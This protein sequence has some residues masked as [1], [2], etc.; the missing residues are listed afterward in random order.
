MLYLSLF[1]KGH[2]QEYFDRLMAVW[3]DGKWEDWLKFFLRGVLEVS[4][5]A[6]E[7]ARSILRLRAAHGQLIRTRIKG[8]AVGLHLLDYLYEQPMVTVRMG[9][10]ARLHFQ[11]RQ[12]AHA[13]IRETGSSHRGGSCAA[14]PPIPL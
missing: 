14:K 4:T 6:R 2:R 9:R 10:E 11:Y 8:N 5:L 1:L 7:K 13:S 12:Q 3:N